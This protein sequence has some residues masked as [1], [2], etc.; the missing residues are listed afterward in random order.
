MDTTYEINFL[1]AKMQ[2]LE[3]AL[4]TFHSN[5]ILNF[6][7]TVVRTQYMDELGNIWMIAGCNR[8]QFLDNEKKFHVALNYYKKEKPFFINAYGLATVVD[9]DSIPNLPTDVLIEKQKGKM[10]LCVK[11]LEANFCEKKIDNEISL[12]AKIKQVFSALIFGNGTISYFHFGGNKT[13][14]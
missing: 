4:V 6:P 8:Y 5:S 1:S 3:T 10:L 7:P 11:I 13:L 12:L 9:N 14:A 2:E